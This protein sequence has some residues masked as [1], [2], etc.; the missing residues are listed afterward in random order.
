MTEGR[1]D[2]KTDRLKTVYPPKLRLRGGGGGGGGGYNNEP[3][4][5]KT[6]VLHMRKQ[7]RRSALEPRS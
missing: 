5:E 6:N 7:R 3:R 4:H 2:G 1:K